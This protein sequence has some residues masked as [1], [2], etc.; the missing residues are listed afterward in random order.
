MGA[1]YQSKTQTPLTPEQ[2]ITHKLQVRLKEVRQELTTLSQR[3]P[4]LKRRL[5]REQEAYRRV[6][7]RYRRPSKKRRWRGNAVIHQLRYSITQ[8]AE[9]S[10]EHLQQLQLARAS[11]WQNLRNLRSILHSLLDA[12]QN[13]R[14]MLTQYYG[15]ARLEALRLARLQWQKQSNTARRTLALSHKEQKEIESSIEQVQKQL[16]AARRQLLK[17]TSVPG[18]SGLPAKS[19]PTSRPVVVGALVQDIER[20]RTMLQMRQF[21][22][23]RTQLRMLQT[24]QEDESIE[25]EGLRHKLDLYALMRKQ[26]QRHVRQ[27]SRTAK[28]GLLYVQPIRFRLVHWK[29]SGMRIQ[30]QLRA[31]P[32]GWQ[33]AWRQLKTKFG[34]LR[35][36]K[37][38]LWWL[39]GLLVA[40]SGAVWWVR[41]QGSPAPVSDDIANETWRALPFLWY[42]IRRVVYETAWATFFLFAVFAFVAFGLPL[43]GL[44]LLW[45][46][47]FGIWVLRIGMSALPVLFPAHGEA[48]LYNSPNQQVLDDW[49]RT[50]HQWLTGSAVFVPLIMNCQTLRIP[51]VIPDLLLLLFALLSVVCFFRFVSHEDD[52][53][54]ALPRF[55]ILER[56]LI[57]FLHKWYRYLMVL[58][59]CFFVALLMGYRNLVSYLVVG[60]IGSAFFGFVALELQALLRFLLIPEEAD[61]APSVPEKTVEVAETTV[62]TE[63]TEA[64]DATKAEET[65]EV[66][67]APFEAFVEA[68]D[69]DASVP[70]STRETTGQRAR[71]SVYL[72]LNAG[73]F[74]VLCSWLLELW[75]VPGGY[76]GLLTVFYTPF[77]TLKDV[78]LSLWSFMKLGLALGG[79]IWIS[80]LLPGYLSSYVYPQLHM[81]QAWQ[82]ASST[83]MRYLLVGMGL[84][85]GLQ[86]MGVG[87]GGFAIFAG[88]L[89]IGLGF[90]I[91]G[92]ANNFLS[93]LIILFGRPIAVGDFIEVDH[94]VGKVGHIGARSTTVVTPSG[95][96]IL[97]PNSTLLNGK[98][99][100]WTLDR[101]YVRDRI[102]LWVPYDSDVKA[103]QS[104]LLELAAQHPDIPATPA[105]KVRLSNFREGVLEMRLTVTLSD[106]LARI[107]ILSDLRMAVLARFKQEGIP[108]A[109]PSQ[110]VHMA[111]KD[112]SKQIT[113][114]TTEP[115]PPEAIPKR[116]LT[117]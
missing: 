88:I 65:E 97:L 84:L 20:L 47:L 43:D 2:Q 89:S 106:P 108:L 99:I 92:I 68:I 79:A 32:A 61:S 113:P 91:Q 49:R 83:L 42:L 70:V 60:L 14:S 101:A 75:H 28:G 12:H 62:T 35:S 98:V 71:G 17:R 45:P 33:K 21:D 58:P 87:L 30:A 90:A 46:W 64:T 1:G 41:R 50:T 37:Q 27:L 103:I 9:R 54:T 85:L 7:A 72:L 52:V 77:F 109:F 93:G 8:Q 82:S 39:L 10:V 24:R 15:A 105:A 96:R 5:L 11:R 107:R 80:R 26:S 111:W 48:T 25:Q 81:T 66:E 73:L 19:A 56:A 116:V 4:Q 44:E 22:A 102:E 86:L 115:K 3:E 69:F 40:V 112:E 57:V 110:E 38:A 117:K 13:F 78:Q 74:L 104:M 6:A 59:L 55:T 63:V 76:K 100:N 29:R 53:L 94:L 34:N 23:Y 18:P 95:K 51:G 16:D 36:P 67:Q 114:G 31:V